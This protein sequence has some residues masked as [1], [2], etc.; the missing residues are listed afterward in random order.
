LGR[1]LPIKGNVR[2]EIESIVLYRIIS[3]YS[4]NWYW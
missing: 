3:N 4:K 1:L 2:L